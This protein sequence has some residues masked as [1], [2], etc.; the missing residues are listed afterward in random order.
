[1]R[2]TGEKIPEF[3]VNLLS[4]NSWNSHQPSGGWLTL[5][6]VYRG[7]WCRHCKRQLQELERLHGD[8][9]ERGV[10]LVAVSADT[11]ERASSM[12][13]DYGLKNLNVGYEMPIGQARALGLFISRREKEIEMPLFCEPGSFLIDNDAR[14]YAAWIASNAFARTDPADMLAYIDFLNDHPDRA[15]RG[16]A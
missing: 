7:M 13:Q 9:L 4:G 1:M 14:I 12:L 10:T 2:K 5:L 15:P 8:F 6:T 3:E 11:E 16:S